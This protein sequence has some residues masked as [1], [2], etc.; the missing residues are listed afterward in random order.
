ME[1]VGL[2]V[3]LSA[4]HAL[5]DE[6]VISFREKKKNNLCSICSLDTSIYQRGRI[7]LHR[8]TFLSSDIALPLREN[9]RPCDSDCHRQKPRALQQSHLPS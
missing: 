8:K 3:L 4:P 2:Q 7:K 5:Y 1:G 9:T 6:L